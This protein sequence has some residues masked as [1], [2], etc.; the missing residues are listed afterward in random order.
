MSFRYPIFRSKNLRWRI[1][2]YSLWRQILGSNEMLFENHL[3]IDR[4]SLS[5]FW[6]NLAQNVLHIFLLR[7]IPTESTN[8]WESPCEP[9]GG[10]SQKSQW[11]SFTPRSWR[12]IS[13]VFPLYLHMGV[14]WNR[15]T[16]KSSILV[17]VSIRNQ[18]FFGDPPWLWKPPSLPPMLDA[19]TVFD[20]TASTQQK[21]WPASLMLWHMA[22]WSCKSLETPCSYIYIYIYIYIHTLHYITL[23]YITLHY[24]TLHY[25]TLLYITYIRT[26]VHT[27]IH[28]YIC[29]VCM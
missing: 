26:Y 7:S 28:T 4:H 1:E 11:R 10:V 3:N 5:I 15:G 19:H 8:R 22:K 2:T 12:R 27:C 21:L 24:I 16:P 25:F 14:S 18:P 9:S 29:I 13:G 17:G 23:L 6:P 20:Q